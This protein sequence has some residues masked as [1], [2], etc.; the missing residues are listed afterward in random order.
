MY[1]VDFISCTVIFAV[2]KA[3]GTQIEEISEEISDELF[4][5]LKAS[6]SGF[7]GIDLHTGVP[8]VYVGV[9]EVS[10]LGL[11]LLA[12]NIQGVFNRYDL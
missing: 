6:V 5:D 1:K 3:N 4:D 2:E 11:R 7:E 9:D 10:E 12:K 8:Q